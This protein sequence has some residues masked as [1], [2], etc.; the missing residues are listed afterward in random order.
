MKLFLKMAH[1]I[2]ELLAHAAVGDL[3]AIGMLAAMGV[4]AIGTA[5]KNAKQ[6]TD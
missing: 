5:V 1:R 2:P 3:W 6:P 4:A